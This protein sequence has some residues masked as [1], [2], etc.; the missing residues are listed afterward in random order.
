MC[1]PLE[2]LENNARAI[3][4]PKHITLPNTLPNTTAA[5]SKTTATL[6]LNTTASSSPIAEN[7]KEQ[8]EE[9]KIKGKPPRKK[10]PIVLF[11]RL[12]FPD[13]NASKFRKM[14]SL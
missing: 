14:S 2:P 11:V 4:K 5:I 9:I 1:Q 12:Y 10:R 3:T 13:H 6:V 7:Q 8:M